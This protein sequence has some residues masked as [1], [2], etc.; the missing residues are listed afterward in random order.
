MTHG[1][2]SRR[3]DEEPVSHFPR[4]ESA[5][6]PVRGQRPESADGPSRGKRTE[7]AEYQLHAQRPETADCPPRGQ[8]KSSADSRKSSSHSLR[9]LQHSAEETPVFR[10]L[11][12]STAFHDANLLQEQVGGNLEKAPKCLHL[13]RLSTIPPPNP[14]GKIFFSASKTKPLFGNLLNPNFPCFIPSYPSFH[15]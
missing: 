11:Q 9:N 10:G 13:P 14:E 8:R 12:R 5:D 7:T 2:V 3:L 1:H 15:F 4:P 6:I